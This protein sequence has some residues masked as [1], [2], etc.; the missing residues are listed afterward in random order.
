MAL[1]KANGV[2][3]HEIV[4]R[5]AGPAGWARI[6]HSLTESIAQVGHVA[7]CVY[8]V[9]ARHADDRGVCWPAVR[10]IARLAGTTERSVRRALKVLAEMGYV[11]IDH[12]RSPSGAPSSNKYYLGPLEGPDTTDRIESDCQETPGPTSGGP[13]A[14]P[15]RT[16]TIGTTHRECPD[17]QEGGGLGGR[18]PKAYAHATPAELAEA[19]AVLADAM[20]ALGGPRQ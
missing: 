11:R 2:D 16:R 15:P 9:L 8:L 17:Y 6:P 20:A 19:R 4:A 1:R 12:R 7:A 13:D 3:Q 18:G 5:T 10:R 14:V